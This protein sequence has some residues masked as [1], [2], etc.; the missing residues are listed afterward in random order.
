MSDHHP[1]AAFACRRVK[2]VGPYEML[3]HVAGQYVH[4]VEIRG[5]LLAQHRHVVFVCNMSCSAEVRSVHL[6]CATACSRGLDTF[7][8]RGNKL[9]E[10]Y[11]LHTNKSELSTPDSMAALLING[12]HTYASIPHCAHRFRVWPHRTNIAAAQIRG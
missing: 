12:P 1:A 9:Q 5:D 2:S 8:R 10:T 4:R 11:S 7:S 3:R 6:K